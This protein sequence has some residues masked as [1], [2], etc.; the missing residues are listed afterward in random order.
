MDHLHII[1]AP[2][3]IDLRK[4]DPEDTGKLAKKDGERELAQLEE[5]LC[6]LQ[7]LLYAA[8]K[9]SILIVLQGMDT[10]GKDG[11]VSH[12]M[13]HINPTG[14]HVWSFKT[15]T[16]DEMAHDFLWRIHQRAPARGMMAIFN[17]SHYEDVLIVRVHD[18][19]PKHIWEAR[20]EQINHFEQMLARNDTIILKFFLHISKDEQRRRL[21][22]R[23]KDPTKSWKLSVGDWQERAFW[24]HYQEAYA[25]AIGKCASPEAP[26]YIVPANKKWYRNYVIAQ[27]ITQRLEAEA[28]LWRKELE[29]RGRAELVALRQY[30]AEHG[31]NGNGDVPAPQ[32]AEG[33]ERS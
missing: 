15:P 22:D 2:R 7:E 19:A 17:R 8:G 29:E 18:L 1:D 31:T 28:N 21:L 11:T 24:H 32:P 4:Y 14:C 5:R 16:F 27:A 20:Y 25:D 23:E 6:A 26:W 9:Q 33:N 3:T 13:S 10:S 12:V 30:R